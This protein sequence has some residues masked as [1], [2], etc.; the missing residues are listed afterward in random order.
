[1]SRAL[2]LT[3]VCVWLSANVSALGCAERASEPGAETGPGHFTA[4]TS[5][6]EGPPRRGSE[7]EPEGPS[8]PWDQEPND[9]R[10]T[11]LPLASGT[12]AQGLIHP[13]A[14]PGQG[15]QDWYVVSVPGTSP[16]ILTATLEGADDL[17]IVLEWM[18]ET[19]SGTRDRALV[20]ADVI[21]KSP[22][23]ERL[24]SLRVE[25][26]K[27]YLR[28]RGAWYRHV[29]RKGSE[30][31]YTLSVDLL[32]WA[33]NLEAEPNDTPDDATQAMLGTMSRGTLGHIGDRD[34]W[35]INTP[36]PA[37]TRVS[38]SIS[39]LDGVTME[40]S[41]RWASRTKATIT[42]R[43]AQGEGIMLRNLTVPTGVSTPALL[44]T[45]R[46]LKGATP[47]F[48]YDLLAQ[49]E[50]PEEG[51]REAEPNDTTAQATKVALDT[52]L[53]GYLDRARDVDM[54]GLTVRQQTAIQLTVSPPVGTNIDLELFNPE[55]ERVATRTAA[56][57]DAAELFRGL[58][59][60]PGTW[61]LAIRGK[62]ANTRA[63]YVL[64]LSRETTPNCETEPNDAPE[65]TTV[66]AITAGKEV[67]G[68]IHP[69]DD[70]DWWALDRSELQG[71]S[72][73][74]VQLDPPGG[75]QL[76]ITV[77]D[78]AG[79][80]VT[81]RQAVTAAQPGTFTHYLKPDSYTVRVSS[82]ASGIGIAAPYVL[83]VLD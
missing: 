53:V 29:P 63:P 47:A 5:Q 79:A 45:L 41:C 28:V 61:H 43:A 8:S 44:V 20:Q 73:V 52:K 77:F 72:I 67:R 49:R 32:P 23:S 33:A 11:A 24:P 59:V 26:G 75:A 37:G 65:Q 70:V 56:P 57:A 2:A 60:S 10:L 14:T 55:G 30:Q 50:P 34:T 68:W 82:S 48:A 69:R 80:E 7:S 58:S 64:E 46:A 38:L 78:S 25:P 66:R 3:C 27:V 39:G 83:R 40:A 19:P 31:P 36:A 15:D 13:P 22:G 76:D 18:P 17:D 42:A 74:T 16:S 4:E 6:P 1:M 81:G 54:I 12:P 71:G 51:E 62:P 35:Y 21:R 9:D